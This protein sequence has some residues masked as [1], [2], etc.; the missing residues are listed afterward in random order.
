MCSVNQ[1][2]IISFKSYLRQ[3]HVLEP[4]SGYLLIAKN[5][6]RIKRI[7]ILNFGPS[8]HETMKVKDIVRLF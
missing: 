8:V 4:I 6:M 3:Q 1:K 5:C 2:Y 7:M